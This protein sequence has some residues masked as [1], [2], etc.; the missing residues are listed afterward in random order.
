MALS[1]ATQSKPSRVAAA[2]PAPLPP[3]AAPQV[4]PRALLEHRVF[5][6]ADELDVPARRVRSALA[7][8]LRRLGE[9]NF[10]CD[11]VQ[12]E[13]DGRRHRGWVRPTYPVAN[14]TRVA[15]AQR[16]CAGVIGCSHC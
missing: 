14:S 10:S 1:F 9:A 3:T 16:A 2:A 12:R 4:V 5:S 7:R 13:L 11:A 15:R 8:W 6:M